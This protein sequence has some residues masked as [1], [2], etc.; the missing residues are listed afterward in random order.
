[1]S[2]KEN[3]PV[4]LRKKLA[5]TRFGDIPKEILIP[6]KEMQKIHFPNITE[7]HEV[8]G[9]ILVY[10]KLDVEKY[11][12]QIAAIYR[13][14]IDEMVGI[15]H[16]EWHHDPEQIIE[17]VKTG[18]WA[19]Y[20]VFLEDRLIS[21]TSMYIHRSMHY[22]Q[23]VWGCVDPELRG[24]GVWKNAGNYLDKV[25]KKSGATYGRVWCATTHSLSQQT[26]ENAG[27]SPHSIDLE[28]L[29]GSDGLGYFQPVVFYIKIY[30]Y[31]NIMPKDHMVITDRV[32]ELLDKCKAIR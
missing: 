29:G 2:K 25:S 6:I 26:V 5:K 21:V 4:E 23:W 28:F 8:K 1:M 13:R 9:K 15:D 7:K 30:N 32:K 16:Y 27:Y 12:T 19:F 3:Q 11:A 18:D 31:N 24:S 14:A 10:T 20:G 22:I 17:H